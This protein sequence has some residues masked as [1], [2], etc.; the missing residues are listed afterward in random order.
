MLTNRNTH[1]WTFIL[2]NLR[3]NSWTFILHNLRGNSWTCIL[4]NLRG[5]SWTCILHNLCGYFRLCHWY[6]VIH[7][8]DWIL[9]TSVPIWGGGGGVTYLHVFN[10]TCSFIRVIKYSIVI[11]LLKNILLLRLHCDCNLHFPICHGNN[12]SRLAHFQYKQH[13]VTISV[14]YH[15][16]HPV[17]EQL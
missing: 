9:I 10:I 5:N 3:G 13:R 11:Y 4:P 6:D 16:K 17:L 15:Q 1:S 14:Q 2:H 7:T 8:F 12:S